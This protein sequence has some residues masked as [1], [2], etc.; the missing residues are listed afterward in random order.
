MLNPHAQR[1]FTI[2]HPQVDVVRDV[3]G[4]DRARS[5]DDDYED[6]GEEPEGT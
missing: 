1:N 4:M 6:S 3:P 2:R 5:E